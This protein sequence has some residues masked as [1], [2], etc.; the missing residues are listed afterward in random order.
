MNRSNIKRILNEELNKS[1]E[2]KIKKLAR[3][4]FDKM[5][6]KH[7]SSSELEKKVQEYVV[8][9]LKKDK[10]TRKEVASITRDVIVKLYKT[11][12]TKKGFWSN[13]LENV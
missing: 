6:K 3:D 2:A 1:D 12:W 11:L 7:L 9:H 5:I 13:G 8:K 4:E 10:P